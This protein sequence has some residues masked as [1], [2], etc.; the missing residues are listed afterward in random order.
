MHWVSSGFIFTV[1]IYY[2]FHSTFKFRILKLAQSW[3]T[4]GKLLSTIA[5][6][7][8]QLGNVTLILILVIYILAVVGVKVFGKMYTPEAFGEDGV[9]RWNFNDFPHAF[10]MVFRILCGEWIEPLWDCMR[11]TNPASILFFVPA[12]V[13]G[14]F[15]VSLTFHIINSVL[16]NIIFALPILSNVKLCTYHSKKL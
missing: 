13:I 16:R 7:V 2:A 1:L 3:S 14:N 15:I 9:P 6:S 8:G 10:M 12:F 5:S 11:V 4:M